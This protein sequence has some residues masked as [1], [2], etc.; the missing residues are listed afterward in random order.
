MAGAACM[1]ALRIIPAVATGTAQ[2]RTKREF[3]IYKT[4]RADTRR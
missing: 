2:L 1:R 4:V 3:I